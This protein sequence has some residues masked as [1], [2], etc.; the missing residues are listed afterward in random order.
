[1]NCPKCDSGNVVENFR[2]MGTCVCK[3][4]GNVFSHVP[5]DMV[6]KDHQV[7]DEKNGKE[8]KK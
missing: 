8:V 1:M 5:K 7:I 6:V 3:K 4:C 2:K